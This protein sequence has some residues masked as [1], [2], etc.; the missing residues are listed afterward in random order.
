MQKVVIHR[1]GGYDRLCI[2]THPDPAPQAHEVLIAVQAIGVNYAD[3]VT[4]MGLYA[5]ARRFVGWPITPGFEVAGRVAAL[6]RGVRDLEVGAPVLAVTL[7]NGYGTRLAVPRQQVFPIPAPL[8]VAEAAAFPTAFLTAWFALFD[9][10]H[11]RP[12][13]SLLV[14]SAAGGVG[15]ALVQLGRLAGCRV[16]GVVGA[17]HKVA[18]VRESGAAGV[19]DKSSQNLWAEARR[20]ATGGYDVVLDANGA[21]T[22]AQSYAH[23]APAGR[24]VVYGFHAMLPCRGGRPNWLRLAWDW[25]RTP[26]FNPLDLTLQNR[27][28]MGFNLS[29]LAHRTDILLPAMEQLLGWVEEGRIR[30]PPVT[31]YPF[32]EVAAAH[33]DLE[34][35]RTVGKLVLTV[36]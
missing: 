20:Y 27:S 19:I 11:P 10:A 6:G 34:S 13:A 23:L 4:R 21:A 33:R 28:V 22:L 35:G 7:F 15:G 14:H 2:E 32:A 17:G 12:G 3:C 29:F 18:A 8:S 1:P 16:V 31:T 5:S 30:P 24:L 9:L 25:L 36:P 26:R